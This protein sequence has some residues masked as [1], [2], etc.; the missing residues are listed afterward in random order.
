MSTDVGGAFKNLTLNERSKAM[1]SEKQKDHIKVLCSVCG[2]EI[3]GTLSDNEKVIEID[4]C[5]TCLGEAEGNGYEANNDAAYDEGHSAGYD[6][7]YTAGYNA[8][9]DEEED[10]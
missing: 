1:W 10:D 6:E 8:G 2:K 9:K 4:P 3:E 5:K 7:G